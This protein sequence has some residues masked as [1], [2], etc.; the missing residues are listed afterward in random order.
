MT[1]L[2][3]IDKKYSHCHHKSLLKSLQSYTPKSFLLAIFCF[4]KFPSVWYAIFAD[5]FRDSF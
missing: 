5:L 3:G 1:Y 2:H 4:T